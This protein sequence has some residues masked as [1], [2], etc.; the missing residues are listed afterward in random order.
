MKIRILCIILLGININSCNRDFEFTPSII[1]WAGE[2]TSRTEN[3]G[4]EFSPLTISADGVLRIDN[5]EIMNYAFKDSVLTFEQQSVNGSEIS[6]SLTFSQF[7]ET[8]TFSGTIDSN[9]IRGTT[10]PLTLFQGTY[11][12]V[13]SLGWGTFYSPL[14]VRWDG[15]VLIA[16]VEITFEYDEASTR[17]TFERQ[18]QTIKGQVPQGVVNFAE[19]TWGD[20]TFSG[21]I[22]PRLDDGP[23]TFIGALAE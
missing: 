23:V 4:N 9:N 7:G 3:L 10:I 14:V 19:A 13:T 12:T 22:N 1:P 17:L 8:K 21:T 6:A 5:E 2:Y 18:R 11:E 20:Y 15:T 16:D